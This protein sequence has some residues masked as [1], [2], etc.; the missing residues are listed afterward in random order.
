MHGKTNHKIFTGMTD[1]LNEVNKNEAD[2]PFV[3]LFHISQFST[4]Q[5]SKF[6]NLLMN[7]ESSI[8]MS[9]DSI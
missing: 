9:A 6:A 5:D 1:T 8:L 2:M 4:D 3:T 7:Q